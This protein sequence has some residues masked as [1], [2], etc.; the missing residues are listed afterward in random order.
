MNSN[1]GSLTIVGSGIKVISQCTLEAQ[2]AIEC[3]DVVFVGTNDYLLV[4]WLKSIN[5]NILPL[6]DL[7]KPS[8][9][10]NE[11]YSLM[12]DKILSAVRDGNDV[13]AVFYG[14]PGI[15][16]SP[17][18]PAISQALAEGYSAR[19]LPGISAEDCLF[20]DLGIDPALRG[21]QSYEATDFFIHDRK[22]DLSAYL[23]LWQIGV[24]GDLK[25][26]ECTAD[27]KKLDL[28]KN[29]LMRYYA[30]DHSVCVY[31]AAVYEIVKPQMQHLALENLTDAAIS[32][33]STL[34]IPPANESV[35]SKSQ[36]ELLRQTESS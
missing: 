31:S 7:Y 21:C 4:A 15:F 23:V 27:P 22:P 20:A 19:M 24:F 10:R 34:C 13:C 36:I 12:T 26:L 28:L 29:Q 16:V 14:H 11:T 35:Q 25:F 3:A 30:S 6:Y 33:E 8:R 17:S 1:K 18:H 5:E 9:P 32:Q 2:R